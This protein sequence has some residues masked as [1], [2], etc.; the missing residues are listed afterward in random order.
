[1]KNASSCKL[2]PVGLQKRRIR[3][4]LHRAGKYDRFVILMK[5]FSRLYT[6]FKSNQTVEG[7]LTE[8]GVEN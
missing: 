8:F 3:A 4:A 1:M 2:H 6:Y 7:R 5:T